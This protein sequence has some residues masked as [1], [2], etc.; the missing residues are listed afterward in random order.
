MRRGGLLSTGTVPRMSRTNRKKIRYVDWRLELRGSTFNWRFCDMFISCM[1]LYISVP[2]GS[3]CSQSF[4]GT[5]RESM[6]Q[7]KIGQYLV[8]ERRFG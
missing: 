7:L 2:S 3:G 5:L 6:L 4:L 8:R 1:N